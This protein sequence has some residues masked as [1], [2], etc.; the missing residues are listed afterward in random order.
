MSIT[1]T[2]LT[3]A[4]IEKYIHPIRRPRTQRAG[5]EFELPI[6]NRNGAAVDFEVVHALTADFIMAFGFSDE[7]RDDDGHIYC[8]AD[9]V[10]GDAL[11]YD[12]SYNTL[13]LSFG[14]EDD[15]NVVYDRFCRYYLFIQERLG[16]ADHMLTGMGVN[17]HWRVN[18][19][20]PIANGRY[21]MLLH[22]LQSYTRYPGVLT[23][24]D[25]PQFGLFSCASQVQLDAEEDT[26]I[27]ALNAFSR[28]E[29][30]KALL[31]ANSPWGDFLCARDHFWKKSMHGVNPRNVDG[32]DAP[33]RDI[34]GLT[35]YIRSMSLYCVEREEKYIHFAPTPLEEYFGSASIRG[36]Y[37]DGQG[38]REIVFSPESGDLAWLR[39]FKFEDLTYRGTI[40]FR[41]VCQQPVRQIMAPAA[42]HAGLMEELPALTELLDREAPAMEQGRTPSELRDLY[43]LRKNP[44]DF[45]APAASALLEK[46]LRLAEQGLEHRGQ[47]EQR[48]L[49][50]MYERA[51]TLMSP[52]GEMLTGLEN[53]K[54]LEYY[55]EDFARLD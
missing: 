43:V 29:P 50:P 1:Q 27:E 39:S 45:D 34:D 55:I 17:P 21:R 6:V 37:Y 32:Y 48:F 38:W 24:H 19:C 12:C 18:R 51:R 5:L 4:I 35:D 53:G 22:H 36:E 20:E 23:F 26:V 2:A 13:E 47:G 54:T 33:L 28:L 10:S 52:A 30:W 40:E 8:A 42:F 46:L 11:S 3:D 25:V 31:F 44:D 14:A 7:H 41:S 9:P 15:L 16:R 49:A